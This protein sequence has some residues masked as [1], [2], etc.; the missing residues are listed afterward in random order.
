MRTLP[1]RRP[2]CFL[3]EL[4]YTDMKQPKEKEIYRHYKGGIYIVEGIATHSEDMSEMV[5]YRSMAA[6]GR[7]FVRPLSM[8][9]ERIPTLGVDRFTLISI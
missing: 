3:E 6:G 7:L 1:V 5:L 4:R 8:W 9:F 2:G